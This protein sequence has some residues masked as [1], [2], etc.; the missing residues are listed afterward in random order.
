MK[1]SSVQAVY[2]GV[3]LASRTR[4][5]WQVRL[6][7]EN[8]TAGDWSECAVFEIGLLTAADWQAQWI[9]GDYTPDPKR[10][11]PVD[12]FQKHF[13]T[14]EVKKA[15]LYATAF[16]IYQAAVNGQTVDGFVLA[17][18]RYRLPQ[19]RAVPDL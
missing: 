11:Y 9:T 10:R 4:V 3:P 16:G 18:R 8:S 19:A 14:R 12:C 2:A 6:W 13:T 7:D 1:S 15:R 5:V 17:P